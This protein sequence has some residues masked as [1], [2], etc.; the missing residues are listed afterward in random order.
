MCN[1]RR[2][3]AVIARQ[4]VSYSKH[5]LGRRSERDPRAHEA[6]AFPSA[7]A[8]IT[9]TGKVS[10]TTTYC[11]TSCQT[12]RRTAWPIA[13]EK[14]KISPSAVNRVGLAATLATTTHHTNPSTLLHIARAHPC[15]PALDIT[16]SMHADARQPSIFG[17]GGEQRAH[18]ASR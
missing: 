7:T 1:V 16:S 17:A 3:L 5:E 12:V 8:S 11:S 2:G 10:S 14:P 13:W 4:S 6:S 18:A 15:P 9:S